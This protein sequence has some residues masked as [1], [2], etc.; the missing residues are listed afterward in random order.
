MAGFLLQRVASGM[1]AMLG[2]S[3]LVFISL[4]AVPGDPVDHLTGGEAT[5]E[6][7]EAMRECMNLDKSMWV[8]W[9]L[10]V[11]N[12][13]DGSLG[14]QCPDPESK[15]T[16]SDRIAYVFPYTAE[17]A[18]GGILLAILFALPLG[19]IAGLYAG[20]WIDTLTALVA[21]AGLSVHTSFMGL[22]CLMIFY[23]DLQ[24][25]PGPSFPDAEFALVL[26]AFVIGTHLMAMIARMTRTSLMNVLSEDYIR[27][28]RSKGLSGFAVTIKHGLRMALL[29]VITIVGLQFGALLAGTIIT[30]KVF[31]RPGLGTLLLDGIAERNYPV[32]Q[33]TALVMA[34]CYV[35]INIMVDI[36]YGVAD[37]RIRHTHRGHKNA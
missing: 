7:R 24:W 30:E 21:L 37:P 19:I 9:G 10:F 8:Q 23:V 3:V 12:I 32:V 36:L 1:A 28:A 20:S 4:H 34:G 29:P 31:A 5:P 6:Q 2:V 17:L 11:E 35:F 25:L 15:P 27:T 26:P 13:F 14:Y 18:L 33:G 22:V 16:V